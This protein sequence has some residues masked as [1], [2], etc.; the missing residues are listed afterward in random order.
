MTNSGYDYLVNKIQSAKMTEYPFPHIR[1]KNF[2]R[3]KDFEKIINSQ[4]ISIKE[5][6]S[7]KE[8]LTN[9]K[10]AGYRTVE[11]PGSIK[12]EDRYIKYIDKGIYDPSLIHGYGK[13]TIGGY[14]L[15]YRLESY[16][17]DQLREIMEFLEGELFL[18]TLRDKFNIESPVVYEGGIQKNLKGYEISPH[19]DTSKKALTWMINIYTESGDLSAKR[20]HT[21]LCQ[22]RR[23]YRYIETFWRD[24]DVDPVWV[25]WDWAETVATTHENNSLIIFKPSFNTLHAVEVSE[26]HL[27]HQRNQIYGNLWYPKAK[28]LRSAPVPRL[29]IMR[30][31]SKLEQVYSWIGKVGAAPRYVSNKLKK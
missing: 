4:Q 3:K 17:C 30:E 22:F 5:S 1:I 31:K 13:G 14:G 24:N 15:T 26:D 12:D 23:E 27:K 25:P 9:L 8:L 19:P 7:T 29:N 20:L 21:Q 2:L 18:R 6:K 11:F 16:N 10:Q 28:K